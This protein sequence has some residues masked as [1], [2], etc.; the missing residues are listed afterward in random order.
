MERLIRISWLVSSAITC[1]D[2]FAPL[3]VSGSGKILNPND[4]LIRTRSSTSTRT[5]MYFD[6]H[7]D[8]IV[9]PQEKYDNLMQSVL[10]NSPLSIRKSEEGHGHGLFTRTSFPAD[11]VAFTIPAEKCITLDN[12]RN[13]PDL[14]KVLTIMEDD[15][16]EEEGPIAT[17]SAFLAS[18]M[19]R[20]ECAEWEEDP[21]ISGSYSQYVKCLPTGRAVSQQDHVLWW[22][23]DEVQRLF[24]GGA[25]YD[26]AIALRDWVEMEGEIIEGM[27][28]S[29][30]AEKNMGLSV[31]QVRRAVTNAFVNVLN[32]SLFN[33][34][35]SQRLVPVLDMCAHAN[36]PN[37]K[38]EV[39]ALGNVVV[40]TMRPI[41][42]GE[43]MTLRYYSSDFEGHEWYVM[44]GFIVPYGNPVVPA[45]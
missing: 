42:A 18:E 45:N 17:L 37:M 38:A 22:S 33:D 39:D 14:G 29:D 16:G 41:L 27:L 12:V 36:F 31:S 26:K 44:Y 28:V 35:E 10:P 3:H 4:P 8:P 5:P 34:G 21:S 7:D 13:H 9:I 24:E 19:L 30:L 40:K 20:E 15:L 23:D 43:E 1:A 11:T 32:R 6:F 2:A 25:A